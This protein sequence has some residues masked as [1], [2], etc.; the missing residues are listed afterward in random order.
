MPGGISSSED[1]TIAPFASTIA[2]RS[3]VLSSVDTYAVTY[4]P[5]CGNLP[6]A[7]PAF[8]IASAFVLN[9][10][11]S[12]AVSAS[13]VGQGPRSVAAGAATAGAGAEP[14]AA[15]PD[16]DPDGGAAL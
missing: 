5:G 6:A 14:V 10:S 13:P 3:R 16:P 4:Q 1:A 9:S 11:A 15:D 8:E 2:E 12:F 7:H